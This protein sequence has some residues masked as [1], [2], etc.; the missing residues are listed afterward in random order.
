MSF[1]VM[2]FIHCRQY[3]FDGE[4]FNINT[5]RQSLKCFFCLGIVNAE[6]DFKRFQLTVS[7]VYESVF[8][9]RRSQI[10]IARKELVLLT[11]NCY[12]SRTADT[13]YIM[14]KVMYVVFNHTIARICT[15]F[16]PHYMKTRE[17]HTFT[18]QNQCY[19]SIITHYSFF[20]SK[21]SSI[22]IDFAASSIEQRGLVPFLRQFT[23]STFSAL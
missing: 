15:G 8:N 7:V 17:I 20:S 10:Y 12:N 16:E 21:N 5:Y 11:G 9:R 2:L 14:K 13:I 23:K 3:G 1:A 22:S 19:K 4:I 6:F 18:I